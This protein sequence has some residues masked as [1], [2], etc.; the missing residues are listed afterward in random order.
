MVDA[1]V[2]IGY[3]CAEAFLEEGRVELHHLAENAAQASSWFPARASVLVYFPSSAHS[4][5]TEADHHDNGRGNC[6]GARIPDRLQ[7]GFHHSA[8]MRSK[9]DSIAL[10][11]HCSDTDHSHQETTA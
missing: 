9:D 3:T 5:S 2:W 4:C 7:R 11:C 10:A 8:L 6:V 1:A